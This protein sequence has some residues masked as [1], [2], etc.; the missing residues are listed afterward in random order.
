MNMINSLDMDH[1]RSDFSQDEISNDLGPTHVS[2][3]R[4]YQ[5]INVVL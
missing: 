1:L 3:R 2:A 5:F 4:E